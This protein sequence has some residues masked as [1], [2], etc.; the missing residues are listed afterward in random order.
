MYKANS[1]KAIDKPVSIGKVDKIY[2]LYRNKISNPR[3]NRKRSLIALRDT[4]AS[5]SLIRSNL[6]AG[7][8]TVTGKKIT[9]RR[10]GN[11][12]ETILVHRIYLKSKWK[13]GI[14][15]IG[16]VETLP[17]AGVSMQVRNDV[18]ANQS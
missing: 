5:Y 17:M 3:E 11:R 13:N 15:N 16:V 14:V 1:W 8:T 9:T 10:I 2:S 18:E 4:G 6:P 7:K 12:S